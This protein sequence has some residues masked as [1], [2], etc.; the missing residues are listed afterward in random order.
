VTDATEGEKDNIWDRLRRRKVVQ[1]GIAYAAGAWGFLQGLAY[2][3]ELL[4]WPA[5]LQKL[6]GLALLIGL[7]IALVLAWYHGDKGE[8]RGWRDLLA[9]PADSARLR[10]SRG[11][12]SCGSRRDPS[13]PDP[14]RPLDRGAPF[15]EHE[16]GPGAGI[17]LRRP[18]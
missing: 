10:V 18:L 13:D 8:R 1:W 12:A 17:F 9:L 6:T 2:V 16:L 3:S 7:P 15:R 4:E 14:Q 11:G 5:Q